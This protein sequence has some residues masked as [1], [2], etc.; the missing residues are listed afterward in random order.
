[1]QISDCY[2]WEICVVEIGQT[3]TIRAMKISFQFLDQTDL[4]IKLETVQLP[5]FLFF[6]RIHS[7]FEL[8]LPVFPQ[9][10]FFLQEKPVYKLNW[11][12]FNFFFLKNFFPVFPM[13]SKLCFN[14]IIKCMNLLWHLTFLP[15]SN[16][17]RKKMLWLFDKVFRRLSKII[18]KFINTLMP[19]S[20]EINGVFHSDEISLVFQ[21]WLKIFF[22]QDENLKF[23]SFHTLFQR[24][25]AFMKVFKFCYNF[26]FLSSFCLHNYFKTISSHRELLRYK[27]F[28]SGLIFA[29]F[30]V[31]KR[32]KIKNCKLEFFWHDYFFSAC[33]F[34]F[35]VE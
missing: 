27:F 32:V 22:S 18:K 5:Y 20:L 26:F 23:F 31:E 14:P 7:H 25:R 17:S 24:A 9:I 29:L 11:N 4:Q 3:L 33:T 35:K 6:W 13:F 10:N 34:M 16:F 8:F 2:N 21:G 12:I 15:T 19:K 30:F 1:M 28:S